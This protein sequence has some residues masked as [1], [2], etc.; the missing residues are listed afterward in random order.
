MRGWKEWYDEH[1]EEIEL[2]SWDDVWQVFA[3]MSADEEEAVREFNE[4][5]PL[6][7]RELPKDEL[8]F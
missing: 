3:Q 1:G 6:P 5:A 2:E 8:P 4:N 7:C